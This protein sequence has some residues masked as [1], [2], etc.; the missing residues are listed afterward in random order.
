MDAKGKRG[1][2]RQSSLVLMFKTTQIIF[3]IW[4]DFPTK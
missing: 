3:G 2:K 4:Q 1:T